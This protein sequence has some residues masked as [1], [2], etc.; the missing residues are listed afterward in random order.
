MTHAVTPATDSATPTRT[1]RQ[2]F[3]EGTNLPE[4]AARCPATRFADE[5]DTFDRSSIAF[6]TVEGRKPP[7]SPWRI[8]SQDWVATNLADQRKCA[9]SFNL[10]SMVNTDG[11]E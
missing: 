3:P 5:V 1:L 6:V 4:Q 9:D 11:F 8:A 2:Y 10:V 7:G